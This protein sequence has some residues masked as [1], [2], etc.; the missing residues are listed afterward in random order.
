LELGVGVVPEGHGI[1]DCGL[2]IADCGLRIGEWEGFRMGN[3]RLEGENGIANT[4]LGGEW[5]GA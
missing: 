4:L 3:G 2:R 1:L 5:V